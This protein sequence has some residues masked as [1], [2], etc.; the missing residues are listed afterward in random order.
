MVNGTMYRITSNE[1]RLVPFKV[2]RVD[3]VREHFTL[4]LQWKHGLNR[5]AGF[6]NIYSLL[7][8]LYWH[9]RIIGFTGKSGHCLYTL[10]LHF[11]RK[12]IAISVCTAEIYHCVFE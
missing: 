5:I 4:T 1:K 6:R 11:A 2:P 12:C 10:V 8:N 7:A 3:Q 9:H